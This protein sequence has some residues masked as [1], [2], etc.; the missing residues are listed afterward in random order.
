MASHC[1]ALATSIPSM[2]KNGSS[3]RVMMMVTVVII[4]LVPVLVSMLMLA[5]ARSAVTLRPILDDQHELSS[6]GLILRQG[7][8]QNLRVDLVRSAVL[9]GNGLHLLDFHVGLGSID[10]AGLRGEKKSTERC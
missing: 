4:R 9:G 6:K 3:R 5:V 2:G 8:S 10:T 1:V 7:G